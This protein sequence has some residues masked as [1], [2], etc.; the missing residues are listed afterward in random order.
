MA[1][2]DW[3]P[4]RLAVAWAVGLAL[5]AGLVA[6]TV[7]SN[8][9]DRER[10]EREQAAMMQRARPASPAERDSV[11]RELRDRYG[12]TLSARGDTIT[13]V[14]LSPEAERKAAHFVDS[15]RGPFVV[16]AILATLLA[17]V[18]YGA[19]P[20]V[21]VTITVVWWRARRSQRLGAAA[22]VV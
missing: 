2:R 4:R 12:I 21:L 1:V 5:E 13:A 19:I 11:F 10:L 22:P 14:Q 9:R 17:A 16:V 20:A 8:Q 7:Y 3:S 6:A 18:V 15:V